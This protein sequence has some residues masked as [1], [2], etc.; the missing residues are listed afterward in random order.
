MFTN[1]AGL[2]AFTGLRPGTYKVTETQPAG[3]L[4]GKDTIGTNGG[5]VGADNFSNIVLAAGTAGVNNVFGEVLASSLSGY[6]YKDANNDGV[7]QGTEAPL[8]GVT[9]KLTGTDDLGNAVNVTAVTNASGFYSFANLRPGTYSVTET[10]PAGYADGKDTIGSQGGTTNA[11][12][13]VI[14]LNPGVAGTANNFGELAAS[15]S[16]KKFFDVSGNG[17]SADDTALAGASF[18]LYL[19]S[20]N[21]GSLETATD[22]VIGT[23]TSTTDGTFS[24]GDLPAGVYFVQEMAMTGFVR[25]GPVASDYYKVNA[26]A[27]SANGTYTFANAEVC[28]KA[29]IN[30]ATLKYIINGTTTVTDLRGKVNAGDTVEVQFDVVEPGETLTLVSYTA[31]GATFNASN[32]S[33]QKIFDVASISNAAVGHYS[34]TV[35]I[36]NSFFQ[37]DFVCGKAIDTFGPAGSNIFYSAQNRLFSADNDGPCL[38][39]KSSLSGF[40][41]VDANNNGVKETT[42]AGIAGVSISLAGVDIYGNT[43]TA[44]TTTDST[45]KYTFANLDASSIAGYRI[46]EAQPAGYFDGKDTIG[47]L[48]GTVANDQLTT[49]RVNTNLAGTGYNFGER[50]P[51][52]VSGYTYVDANND[53]VK[54]TTE[55]AIAGVLVTLT[56][57]DDLGAAVNLTATTDSTGYYAFTNLR[58]GT[59]TLQETQPAGY[60]D[61]KDTVGTQGGTA[62]NDKITNIVLGSGVNS[63]TGNNFGE[64]AGASLSGYVYLDVNND[65]TKQTTETGI[66]GATVTLTGTNDLGAAVTLTATTNSTGLYTFANLRPGTYTITETQP[67]GYNDGK[68]TLGS[69]GGTMTNDKFATITVAPAANGANYNFGEVGGNVACGDSATIG[70]WQNNNGQ[71]LINSLNG[72]SSDTK[73]A[74]WLATTYPNLY[75]SACGAK[76]MVSTTGVYKTNAQ[77]AASY[78]TNFF[79]VSG[80]KSDAQVL[81][82]A[83]SVYV[84]NSTLAGG[85]T[86]ASFGFNV[87]TVGSG[88]KQ[89]NVGTNGAA[90]GVANNTQMTLNQ[91]LAYANTKSAKGVLY[92]A[93]TTY[94]SACNTVFSNVNTTGDIK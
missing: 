62:T 50:L 55:A 40:A 73:L 43:V 23:R 57:T 18:K 66:S 30:P 17:L 45:G 49:G 64:L 16:G 83:L 63:G 9:V 36:P 14:V 92:S 60:L 79:S 52:S 26:L 81:C 68:D 42:E 89:F 75:G 47:S 51:S 20:N 39:A 19:D 82:T 69:I 61:G 44:T 71:C 74:Q 33:Q 37:V 32:A 29:E 65:G 2:Y 94:L 48:G 35:L 21:S 59:Y 6:V 87:S 25:T 12:Q 46:T 15:I 1:S 24:F 93:A 85:T 22:T 53:G 91:L 67:A 76:A 72:G 54:Q 4:D 11:D 3:Y 13:F 7:F 84:S 86:A 80:M 90:F 5:T 31:P 8:S 58:P 41:Y 27:G 56:G 28:D 77:V 34:L 88:L 78:I 10:Q 38:V 70:Y